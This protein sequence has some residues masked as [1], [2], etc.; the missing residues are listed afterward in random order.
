MGRG[1][2]FATHFPAMPLPDLTALANLAL[3]HLGEPYLDD[4]ATDSGTTAEAVRLH[5]PRC[6]EG[7]LE[8]HVWAFA[9][10]TAELLA[11]PG[12][13]TLTVAGTLTSDGST[14]VTFP[15][16]LDTGIL[17][18]P[19]PF[20]GTARYFTDTGVR[21][22]GDFITP[23]TTGTYYVCAVGHITAP[24]I[25][26][27]ANLIRYVD[28]VATE[29]YI[30]EGVP[31]DVYDPSVLDWTNTAVSPATGNPA[32]TFTPGLIPP[33]WGS[34]FYLPSDLVRL[35]RINEADIDDIDHSRFDIQGRHLMLRTGYDATTDDPPSISYISSA[36]PVGEWPNTFVDAVAFLLAARLAPKLTGSQGAAEGYLRSHELCLAKARGKATPQTPPRQ[37]QTPP[38]A[39]ATSGLVRARYGSLQPPL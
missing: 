13:D 23:P 22:D 28:A 2:S 18:L 11:A 35:I 20:T 30:A 12:V 33:G 3:D 8:G 17:Q 5:L 39:F 16:L 14:A 1:L 21:P 26:N 19:T 15:T 9:T 29:W 7:I 10:R 31:S 24:T 38:Q 34:A 36:A 37:N 4:Y 6:V 27:S 25:T 32:L